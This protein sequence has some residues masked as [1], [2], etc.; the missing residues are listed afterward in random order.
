MTAEAILLAGGAG[1]RFWPRSRAARP[2]QFLPLLSD[3]P[4]IAETADR[5][6]GLVSRVWVV[7]RAEWRAEAARILPDATVLAESEG[8]STAAALALVACRV[9]PETVLLALPADHDIP[10]RDAFRAAVRTALSAAERHD[11]IVCFGIVP[12]R[13]ETGYGYILRGED[14]GGGVFRIARFVEKPPRPRAEALVAEGALWNGGI[15]AF[16]AG[17]LMD[18]VG[19]HLPEHAEGF[20]RIAAAVGT[21]REED[22]TAAVY[23]V[24]PSISVDHG[25]LEK[26]DRA[27]AVPAD[28]GWDDVGDWEVLARRGRAVEGNFVGR[29]DFVPLAARGVLSDTD[30]GL[31]AAIGVE[32]LVVVRDGDVVLVARRKDRAAVRDLLRKMKDDPALRA[33]L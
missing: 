25:V 32:D 27:L 21:P 3:R 6:A 23:S 11:G 17:V 5:V 29:G 2:K 14:L 8:R 4:M 22:E 15:F 1:E 13:P 30:R 28:F 24:L 16:R 19:R 33:Y 18:E 10:D 9:P 20:R 12:T 26:T 31:V 7:T